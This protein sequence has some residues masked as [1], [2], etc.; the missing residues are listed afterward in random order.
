MKKVKFTAFVLILS[1]VF[2]SC[3]SWLQG[4][5]DMN[6]NSNPVTLIDLFK[7]Q[8]K[9]ESLD[10]PSEIFASQGLYTGKIELVWS[11]VENATSYIIERAVVKTKASDGTYPLP[12]ESD[13]TIISKY[14]LKTSYSDLILSSPSASSEEYKYHYF[15]RVSAENKEEA[16]ISDSTDYT[17]AQTRA[18]GWLFACPQN[19]EADKGKST[20]LISLTW[21]AVDEAVMYFIYRGETAGTM[22]FLDYVYGNTLSYS[23]EVTSAEQGKEFYYKV[24]AV[25]ENKVQSV[26]SS[27]AMGYSL[28]EGAPAVTA[29]VRVINGHGTSTTELSVSWDEVGKTS[30]NAVM[31]YNLYRTSSEDSVYTRLKG[32]LT[33]TSYT[34]SSVKTGLIYYYYVQAVSTE[35]DEV[36]K[37]AFS[38]ISSTSWG[39]LLSPVSELEI[40]DGSASSTVT[41]SWKPAAGWEAADF[42]YSIYIS[43][44]QEG[45]YHILHPEILPVLNSEGWYE[46]ET[47]KN[48]FF[49]I[50][51]VNLSSTGETESALS[52]AAAPVPAA[53]ENVTASKT[54]YMTSSLVPNSN[55]VYPVK[56]TWEKPETDNPAGYLVYRSAK[57]GSGF[58]KLTENPVTDCQFIDDSSENLTKAGTVYYYKVISVNSLGS[59]KKGNNPQQEYEKAVQEGTGFTGIKCLGYG[60]L[61]RE[62]WFREYNKTCKASQKKLTLMHKPSNTDKLGSETVY[63]TISGSLYYNAAVDGLGGYVTMRYTDYADYYINDDSNLG[64]YF[65]G[66]GNTDTKANMSGSGNMKGTMN[67][68]GMYPG[69][70]GYDSLV[71][72]G[73]AAGGGT[74]SVTVKDLE[75]NIILPEADISWLIGEE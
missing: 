67:C 55:N 11:E 3:T 17:D 28:A 38:E 34:D 15:Y 50:S 53:P 65:K 59:G 25:N 49:K 23:N 14:C 26:Y 72:K 62:Q 27:E 66:S 37:G 16:L 10:P 6:R 74:Y 43:S 19:V 1:S 29:N 18:E 2:V 39:F 52:K 33:S 70:A 32:G 63:G 5:V 40:G 71:I 60:V 69:S 21:D 57:T 12:D 61:T 9:L 54:S 22:E 58:R 20:S 73:S 31:T 56:I 30:E 7:Q 51:T 45:T 48:P 46:Y 44:E 41:V 75:G 4:K 24:A 36:I 68:T 8:K 47:G 64:V 35:E 42:K 13:F